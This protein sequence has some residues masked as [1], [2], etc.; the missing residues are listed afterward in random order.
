MWRD[1]FKTIHTYK[2]RIS[3]LS[4]IGKH[5]TKRVSNL[6]K[7]IRFAFMYTAVFSSLI[8]RKI[9]LNR[10]QHQQ[11]ENM[12]IYSYIGLQA[13]E[14]LPLK[15]VQFCNLNENCKMIM[16][17]IQTN[18]MYYTRPKLSWIDSQ[19]SISNAKCQHFFM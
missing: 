7:L 16:N 9:E 13:F 14:W 8:M 2:R 19:P 10:K 5:Q 4:I 6:N 18:F 11:R 3:L 1:C 12:N 15:N 17:F